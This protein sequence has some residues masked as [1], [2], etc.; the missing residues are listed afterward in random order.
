MRM[1]RVRP[2][3]CLVYCVF[4]GIFAIGILT[5]YRWYTMEYLSY[6]QG[7]LQWHM[8]S[9]IMQ[10]REREV[11]PREGMQACKH[12]DLPVHDPTIM[13]FFQTN[14]TISCDQKD[15][16]WVEV[17]GPV[18]SI[19]DSAVRIHGDITCKAKELLRVTDDLNKLAEAVEFMQSYKLMQSDFAEIT[20]LAKDGTKWKSIVAGIQ[21]Q[22]IKKEKI[23]WQYASSDGLPLN[24]LIWGYDS[25]SRNTFIRKLPLAYKY[26][27]ETL[28][29]IVLH[30]YNIVGDGT[31]QALTPILTGRTE[32]ELPDCRKRVG[33]KAHHVDVYPMIWKDFRQYGYVTVLLNASKGLS[34]PNLQMALLGGYMTTRTPVHMMDSLLMPAELGTRTMVLAEAKKHSNPYLYRK[35]G[36]GSD[37]SKGDVLQTLMCIP[38]LGERK[39]ADLLKTFGSLPGIVSASQTELARVIGPALAGSVKTWLNGS[40]S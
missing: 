22:D 30:G 8:E 20:C 4:I 35:K 31:P 29:A 27:T 18:I 5:C 14:F 21:K 6:D 33:E 12:P 9:A 32:L 16:D 23:G 7:I 17:K 19:S 11:K 3:R 37:N 15:P 2:S 26:L 13:K 34:P 24:V 25:L 40:K 39:A 36:G 10:E 28:E 1:G 38:K